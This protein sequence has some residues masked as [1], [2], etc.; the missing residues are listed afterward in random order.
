VLAR[1]D[2]ALPSGLRLPGSSRPLLFTNR[3][4]WTTTLSLSRRESPVSV[5]DNISY[6]LGTTLTFQF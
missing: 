5:I 2:L 4:I 3:I 6:T 1:A